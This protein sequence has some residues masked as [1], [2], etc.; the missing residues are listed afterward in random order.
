MSTNSNLYKKLLGVGLA[1]SIA[2]AGAFLISPSEGLV[3]KT[4]IDPVNI[5]TSC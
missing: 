3:N 4:Y 5:L 1:S 2:L